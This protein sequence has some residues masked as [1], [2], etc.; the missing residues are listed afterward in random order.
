MIWVTLAQTVVLAITGWLIWSYTRET[1]ALRQEM[2]R[3]NRISLRPILLPEF[4]VGGPGLGSVFRLK[5]SGQGCAV[6]IGVSPITILADQESTTGLGPC[7]VR[8]EPLDYLPSGEK[9]PVSF[10]VWAGGSK[11]IGSPFDA[12]FFPQYPGAGT[13]IQISFQDVEGNKYAVDV[14]IEGE[15][16]RA[17]LPRRVR[18]GPIKQ[19]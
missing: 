1:A 9:S 4:A 6:N 5:N 2:V 7:E 19:V 12:Y 16:D 8:F 13:T 3:Q 14:T 17:N 18:I 15:L 11:T 10:S